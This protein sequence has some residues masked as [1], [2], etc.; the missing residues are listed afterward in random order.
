VTAVEVEELTMFCRLLLLAA[1]GVGGVA[2]YNH[3]SNNGG[4]LEP[5]A[6]AIDAERASRQAARLAGRAAAEAGEAATKLGDA[7]GANAVTMKIKSKMALDDNIDAGNIHVDIADTTVT[8]TGVVRS[9][10]ER[11]RAVRLARETRGV[12]QVVDRLRI[13]RQ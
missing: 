13:R 1:V 5:R 11:D 6:A 8:L 9:A 12:T 10:D 7:V 4:S 2:A 3:W